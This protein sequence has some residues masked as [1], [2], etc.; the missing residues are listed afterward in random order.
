MA[1]CR[2]ALPR[3]CPRSDHRAAPGQ[4]HPPD[5]TCFLT[6]LHGPPVPRPH[7]V[8]GQLAPASSSHVQ[9]HNPQC[10]CSQTDALGLSQRAQQAACRARASGLT[11]AILAARFPM[12]L[13][14]LYTFI[15]AFNALHCG[16]KTAHAMAELQRASKQLQPHL[17]T[18]KQAHNNLKPDTHK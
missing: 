11:S 13:P 7:K 3:A 10:P 17:G 8:E 14:P 5:G 18:Q 4:Q 9:D 12:F 6:P 2:P 16:Y 1:D 15:T